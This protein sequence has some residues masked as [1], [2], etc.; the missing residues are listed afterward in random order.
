M[1]RAMPGI[2]ANKRTIR[3]RSERG[4]DPIHGGALINAQGVVMRERRYGVSDGGS[5][6]IHAST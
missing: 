5:R 2:N 1:T 4:S 3:E 6:E